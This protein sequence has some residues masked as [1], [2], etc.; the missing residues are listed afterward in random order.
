MFLAVYLEILPIFLVL[1]YWLT[2]WAWLL[3]L[4]YFINLDLSPDK[5]ALRRPFVDQS[6]PKSSLKKPSNHCSVVAERNIGLDFL[7]SGVYLIVF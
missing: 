2:A 4:E 1:E 5:R 6:P 7:W 3:F